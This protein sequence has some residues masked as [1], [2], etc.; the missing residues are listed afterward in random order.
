MDVLDGVVGEVGPL[1]SR[2]GTF[3]ADGCVRRCGE[4]LKRG[5]TA[6]RDEGAGG[7]E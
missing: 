3:V 2:M 1:F 5:S 6:R 4:D 7:R